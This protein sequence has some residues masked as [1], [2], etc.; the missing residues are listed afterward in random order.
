MPNPCLLC[1]QTAPG[2]NNCLCN[3]CIR[4]L[5]QAGSG[6]PI[7][8]VPLPIDSICPRC[9]LYPP[10]FSSC[11]AP[12]IYR[13]PV[14]RL[15]RQIKHDPHSALFVQFCLLMY[16]SVSAHYQDQTLPKLIIPMPLHWRRTL[17]RGFNQAEILAHLLATSTSIIMDHNS[18]RRH[19]FQAPQQAL[20]RRRR[21]HSMRKAFSSA[22]LP[23]IKV[24][25]VDDV[26]TTTAS[27][28]ALAT[29]LIA[30]GA[31]S[32]DVWAISRTPLD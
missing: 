12:L 13:P 15:I 22:P 2:K 14:D 30:A 19:T 18:A 29:T 31:K 9:L 1:L 24:A 10:A 23:A 32:V 3:D 8:A 6:C 27:S 4:T 21:H 20:N 11:I 28:H 7:C 5:P 17:Q 25:L 26:V 16:H